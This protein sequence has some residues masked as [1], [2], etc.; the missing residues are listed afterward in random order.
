MTADTGPPHGTT[1]PYEDLGSLPDEIQIREDEPALDQETKRQVVFR[2]DRQNPKIG[3]WHYLDTGESFEGTPH[4]PLFDF[5][6][7]LGSHPGAESV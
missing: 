7:R 1:S 3:S 6:E 5:L 2:R 4:R